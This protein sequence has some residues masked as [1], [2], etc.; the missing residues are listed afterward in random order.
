MKSI[1]IPILIAAIFLVMVVYLVTFQVRETE[2]AFVTRFGKPVREVTKPGLYP[3][4]P[5]PVEQV[6]KFDSRMRVLEA[7]LGETTTSGTVPI[8]VNTYVVWRVA[9]PLKFLNAVKTVENAESKLRN[10]INDT[11]NRVIGQHAF[12]EFVNSDPDKIKFDQIQMEMLTD[13]KEPVLKDYG[14]EIKTLGIKQLKISADVTKQVFERMK[15][16]RQRRTEATISEG[17]AEAAKIQSEANKKQ[18]VLL[19]AAEA[20]AKGIR[21][22][23]DAEAAKYYK[24]LDEDPQLAMFLRDLETLVATTKEHATIVIPAT[25]AP[26]RLLTGMPSLEPSKPAAKP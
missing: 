24:M 26:F 19:A 22:T 13:L 21:G 7:E 16:E 4:W 5:T 20:R 8:I 6:H 12:G 17:A 14:I 15:A 3:K 9:E 23:G 11:Q 1:A 25:A 2:S 18:E 10:Q